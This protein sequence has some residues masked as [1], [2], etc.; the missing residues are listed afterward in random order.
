MAYK[1]VWGC[2]AEYGGWK[3]LQWQN[4]S[5]HAKTTSESEIKY[6]GHK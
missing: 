6:S 5:E 2:I 1:L 3:I 4:I